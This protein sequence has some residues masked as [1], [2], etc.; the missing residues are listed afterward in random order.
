[1]TTPDYFLM[2]SSI[3]TLIT[4]ILIYLTL[5]EMARQRKNT[6]I[7]EIVPTNQRIVAGK[8]PIA[9][10]KCPT[11][12]LKQ[13][14]HEINDNT[15]SKKTH[16]NFG[17]YN[18]SLFN[19][20]NGAAK[21]ISLEW[22]YD[23]KDFCENINKLSQQVFA[24]F[25]IELTEDNWLSFKRK[26]DAHGTINLNLD[27][28]ENIDYILPSSVE[29]LG[30]E[31]RFPSSYQHLVSLYVQ[32]LSQSQKYISENSLLDLYPLKLDMTYFDIAGNKIFK[33]FEFKVNVHAYMGAKNG[34]VAGFDAMLEVKK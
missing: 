3:A 21:D 11:F 17:R 26:T 1:L 15:E 16:Y 29:R 22:R 30:T 19:L 2:L 20:G 12:W 6:I 5:R 7:P 14:P 32:I 34:D 10:T 9:E 8:D 25:Y 33:S 18:I 31:V 4:A 24:D 13:Y 23:L 28:K 27:L